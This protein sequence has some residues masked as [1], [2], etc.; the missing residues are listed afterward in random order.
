MP[1]LNLDIL[2]IMNTREKKRQQIRANKLKLNRSKLKSITSEQ[3]KQLTALNNLNDD[4]FESDDPT[5][6]RYKAA[7]DHRNEL[8]S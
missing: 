3:K 7:E 4:S 6:P 2:N 1:E 5:L 8:N